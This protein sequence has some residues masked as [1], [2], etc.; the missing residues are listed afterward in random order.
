MTVPAYPAVPTAGTA[1]S[2]GGAVESSVSSRP[3]GDEGLVKLALFKKD[4]CEYEDD[5]DEQGIPE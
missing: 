3:T 2:T 5:C 1:V 4:V